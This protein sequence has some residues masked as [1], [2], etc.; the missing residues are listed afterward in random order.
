GIF[1]EVVRAENAADDAAIVLQLH[2]LAKLRRLRT[3][4]GRDDHERCVVR[5][6]DSARLGRT[7]CGD[8]LE[9][10]A[11]AYLVGRGARQPP[12]LRGTEDIGRAAVHEVAERL[13]IVGA[14]GIV[15]QWNIGSTK[16]RIA[17]RERLKG[18]RRARAP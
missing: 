13:E 6:A 17:G 3:D 11:I 5:V 2:F 16:A 12:D 8:A 1:I 14:A 18:D 15:D 4:V 9:G 7:V 10:E